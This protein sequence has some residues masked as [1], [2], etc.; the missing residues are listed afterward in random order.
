MPAKPP[1]RYWRSYGTDPLP[2]AAETMDQPFAAFPSWLMKITCDRCSKDRFIVETH[3]DR[4]DV[5]LRDIIQ[6]GRMMAA[7]AGHGR[8]S[9]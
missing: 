3:F 5:P 9:C 7:A 4:R 8:W 6:R 2:T 1:E